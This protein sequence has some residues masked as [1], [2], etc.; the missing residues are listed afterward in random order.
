MD[1]K[2]RLFRGEV[3]FLLQLVDNAHADAAEGSKSKSGWEDFHTDA[4]GSYIPFTL[5][6]EH[7][8]RYRI[9]VLHCNKVEMSIR[10]D[11]HPIKR[12]PV[13]SSGV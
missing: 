9:P 13:P 2:C 7:R 4:R 12:P 11:I 8:V 5:L 3:T 6:R 1:L 10:D